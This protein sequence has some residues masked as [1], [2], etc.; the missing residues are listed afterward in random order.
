MPEVSEVR[1]YV[2]KELR[3]IGAKKEVLEWI[4]NFFV[5]F[6]TNIEHQVEG[7]ITQRSS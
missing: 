5:K 6:P 7:I 3:K 4:D 2:L 1:K